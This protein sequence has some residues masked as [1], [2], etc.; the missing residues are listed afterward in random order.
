[1]LQHQRFLRRR[2]LRLEQQQ[3]HHQLPSHAGAGGRGAQEHLTLSLVRPLF[4]GCQF[5]YFS[6]GKA[7]KLSTCGLFGL[8]YGFAYQLLQDF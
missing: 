5:V 8:S 4:L 1:M 7:S 2:S 3:Q 6:T